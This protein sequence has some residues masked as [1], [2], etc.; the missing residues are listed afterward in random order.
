MIVAEGIETLEQVQYLSALGCNVVQG[1]LFSRPVLAKH[2]P[3]LVAKIFLLTN[4]Q[5]S[6]VPFRKG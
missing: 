3:D 1:Y 2:I 6:V 4:A 5:G